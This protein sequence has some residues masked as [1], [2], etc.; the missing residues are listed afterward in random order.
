MESFKIGKGVM[1]F[2]QKLYNEGIEEKQYDLNTSNVSSVHQIPNLYGQ[3]MR[4][5]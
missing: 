1:N 3:N 2:F 5:T 4:E